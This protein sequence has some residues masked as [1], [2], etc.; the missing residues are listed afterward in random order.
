[1]MVDD[2]LLPD[3]YTFGILAKGCLR[4]QDGIELLRDMEV[5]RRQVREIKMEGSEREGG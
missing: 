3:V 2:G 4:Q 1:M 5:E